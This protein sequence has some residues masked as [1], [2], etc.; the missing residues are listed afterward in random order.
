MS[1]KN[2]S[3]DDIWDKNFENYTTSAAPYSY[4]PYRY[5]IRTKYLNPNIDI[6]QIVGAGKTTS[7]GIYYRMSENYYTMIPQ[8]IGTAGEVYINTS[9]IGFSYIYD[10]NPPANSGPLSYQSYNFDGKTPLSA[11]LKSW[12][13]AFSYIPLP[14]PT[15]YLTSKKVDRIT[16]KRNGNPYGYKK[17]SCYRKNR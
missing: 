4:M 11:S 17:I 13:E 6:I 5:N 9:P 7:N 14:A 15:G 1:F 10:P 3:I 8:P 12:T 16:I 2:V